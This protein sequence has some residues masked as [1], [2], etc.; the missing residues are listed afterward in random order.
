MNHD[1]MFFLGGGVWGRFQ[2]FYSL[3]VHI[4]YFTW[5][6]TFIHLQLYICINL[7]TNLYGC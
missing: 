4:S 2:H 6:W 1:T 7:K 3:S 5:Y